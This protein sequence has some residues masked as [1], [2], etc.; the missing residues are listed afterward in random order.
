M[1][2]HIFANRSFN[3]EATLERCS[4]VRAIQFSDPPG[5]GGLGDVVDEEARDAV[6]RAESFGLVPLLGAR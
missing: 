4:R 2:L 3:V 6:S 5:R 1:D